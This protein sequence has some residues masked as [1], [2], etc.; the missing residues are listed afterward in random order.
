MAWVQL[1]TL[2]ALAQF[3]WL[4]GLVGAARGRYGIAAPATTGNEM[5]ER[6]YRVHMN[7]LE[8][9]VVFLPAMWL[10]AYYW[11]PQWVAGAGVV[12]LI[13]RFVYLR[14]YLAD[15]KK[16]GPGYGLSA[17]PTVAL[18]LAALI[19]AVRSLLG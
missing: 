16:R 15:P 14:G 2:L 4:G 1:V 6:Y 8:T 7:T 17:L 11:S 19:G 10:A 13:G 5:F 18:L 12:Y 9:M 3:I